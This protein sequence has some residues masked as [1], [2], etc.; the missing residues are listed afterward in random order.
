MEDNR[1]NRPVHK[2]SKLRRGRVVLLLVPLPG[3]TNG[4]AVVSN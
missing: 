1:I 3:S 4:H 2:K